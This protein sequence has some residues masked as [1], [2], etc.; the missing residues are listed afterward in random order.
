MSIR[1]NSEIDGVDDLTLL[2]RLH[3]ASVLWNLRIRFV[4]A[5]FYTFIGSILV[6]INPYSLHSNLYGLEMAK[7][8]AGASVGN[9][10]NDFPE[11]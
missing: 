5:K 8:Y 1:E 6:S 4:D 11:M 9:K 2:K 10:N 3:E 7:K